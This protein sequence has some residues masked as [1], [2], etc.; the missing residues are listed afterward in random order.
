MWTTLALLGTLTLAPA[1]A[2]A[3]ECDNARFTHGILG[4]TRKDDKFLPGDVVCMVF[5]VKGLAV[6][7]D[8]KVKYSM[9]FEVQKKGQKN[10]VLK[11]EPQDLEAFNTL[12]TGT[13]PSFATWPIPRDNEAPG[14]YTLKITVADTTTKKSTTLSK[15]FEVTPTKLG[16]VQVYLTS[17]SRDPVPAPPI[18]VV[19]QRLW[20]NYQLVGFEIDKKTRASDVTVT[21][22]VLDEKGKPTLTKPFT[23]D[24]KED[25][26]S[27]PGVMVFV[28]YTLE[29]NRSGKFKIELAAKCKVCGKDIVETLDLSVNE[30]K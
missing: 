8:G 3:P 2:G 16:F 24:I 18:A 22:R 12:G 20:L 28:P 23:G 4:Q 13:F 5:D 9:G 7:D 6:K 17:V 27:A 14:K 1:Q 25:E 10:P 30:N 11:R 15:D 29:L 19:G 26:K 21:V